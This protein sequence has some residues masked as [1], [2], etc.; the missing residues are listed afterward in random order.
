MTSAAGGA[1]NSAV[2]SVTSAV[3]GAT[4]SPASAANALLV[5][6]GEYGSGKVVLSALAAVG[7]GLVFWAGLL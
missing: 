7:A 6:G 3:A 1:V 4:S 2:S 5:G